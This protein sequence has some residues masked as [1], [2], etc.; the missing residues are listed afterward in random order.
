[1]LCFDDF[2]RAIDIPPGRL[3]QRLAV[4]GVLVEGDQILLLSHPKTGWWRL[5]GGIAEPKETPQAA[6]LRHFRQSA[7]FT[8]M[9]G[10]LLLVEDRY[11]ADETGQGWLLVSFYYGLR[12]Q[13]TGVAGLINFENSAHPEWVIVTDLT[14]DRLLFGYDAIQ[15][16]VVQLAVQAPDS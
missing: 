11:W 10:P 2:G 12:R 1:M 14:R 16:R 9:I 3:Q 7:N 8:P 15:A 5:P 6:L 13:T 4:Y